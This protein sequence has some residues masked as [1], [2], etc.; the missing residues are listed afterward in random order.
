MARIRA[1]EP[2]STEDWRRRGESRETS[3]GGGKKPREREKMEQVQSWRLCG[4]TLS[5][6]LERKGLAGPSLL[7]PFTL[8]FIVL[9]NILHLHPDRLDN[10]RP[11]NAAFGLKEP[12][13]MDGL[14]VLRAPP[15]GDP[16]TLSTTACRITFI[17][18]SHHEHLLA[19][20]LTV[21]TSPPSLWTPLSFSWDHMETKQT[22]CCLRLND[23]E[24]K[25]RLGRPAFSWKKRGRKKV[26][27][28]K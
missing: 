22:N 28:Q 4:S 1:R 23:W 11:Q 15:A 7:L 16:S 18:P 25:G 26:K 19:A 2:Y 8:H 6:C 5:T 3:P 24:N 21:A 14:D 12:Q 13:Y 9:I 17:T 27:A 10:L 20:E